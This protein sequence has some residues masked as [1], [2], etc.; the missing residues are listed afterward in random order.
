MNNIIMS[1][2]TYIFRDVLDDE[3]IVIDNLTTASDIDGWDSLAHIRLVLTV[4]QSFK[5]KFS[6]KE[7]NGL[8]NVGEFVS[9]IETKSR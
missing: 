8:K 2:L 6:A 5:V 4:E 9:L 3:S 1:K 7:V